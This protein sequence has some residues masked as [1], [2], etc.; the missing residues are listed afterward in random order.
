MFNFRFH[1]DIRQFIPHDQRSC[2][3]LVFSPSAYK[4]LVCPNLKLSS[5]SLGFTLDLDSRGWILEVRTWT[6]LS[7]FWSVRLCRFPSFWRN[8]AFGRVCISLPRD[9]YGAARNFGKPISIPLSFLQ[10]ETKAGVRA[11]RDYG[12]RVDRPVNTCENLA[13]RR[14]HP[15]HRSFLPFSASRRENRISPLLPSFLRW[16]TLDLQRKWMMLRYLWFTI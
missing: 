14:L 15:R 2:L 10:K 1:T 9:A 5:A 13:S 8:R 4:R 16:V 11:P 12:N 3:F 6:S 7:Q